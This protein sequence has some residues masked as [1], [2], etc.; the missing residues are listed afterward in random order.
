MTLDKDLYAN[1]YRTP[2][3]WWGTYLLKTPDPLANL[4]HI[5]DSSFEL[6][7][8]FSK[9]PSYLWTKIV[10]FFWKYAEESLEV[11]VRLYRNESGDV[12]K[13]VVPWH[14]ITSAHVDFDYTKGMCDIETG[15]TLDVSIPGFFYAG[16]FH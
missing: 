6:K 4:T 15:E 7:K 14:E 5:P 12:W 8:N 10:K 16:T 3:E 2:N 1:V 9:I 13:V 11:M